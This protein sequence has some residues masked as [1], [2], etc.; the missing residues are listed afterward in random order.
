MKRRCEILHASWKTALLALGV[1][2]LAACASSSGGAPTSAASTLPA[3]T[4]AP[5]STAS[6]SPAGTATVPTS[7][8][9]S[10]PPAS[11]TGTAIATI[12]STPSAIPT[13]VATSLPGD[14]AVG[15]QLFASQPCSSCHDI[16]QPFP[17]GAICPNLGNI[18]TEAE[19]IV[20]SPDYHGKA[21]DAAGYIRESIVNPNAY[22]VPGAQYRTADG[23]SVM[24]KDFGQKLTPT[25]IDDLVAFLMQHK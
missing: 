7:G 3:V 5:I 19:R 4:S 21:T 16:T 23:Q 24:P 1:G 6:P 22:I 15:A 12:A 10:T 11:P 9:V 17:G 2:L 20:H 18:A 13:R 14:P 8:G 25:Q